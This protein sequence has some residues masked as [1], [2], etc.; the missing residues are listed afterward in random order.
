[1]LVYQRVV[2]RGCIRLQADGM[3][4]GIFTKI[5]QGFSGGMMRGRHPEEESPDSEVSKKT[6]Q[7]K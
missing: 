7:L 4:D 3:D 2:F 6:H 1:M 5:L